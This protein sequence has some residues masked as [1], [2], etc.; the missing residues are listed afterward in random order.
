MII[1]FTIQ[2]SFNNINEHQDKNSIKQEIKKNIQTYIFSLPIQWFSKQEQDELRASDLKNIIEE[3]FQ[4]AYKDHIEKA[5]PIEI[6]AINHLPEVDLLSLYLDNCD[7][8]D[9]LQKEKEYFW[10]DYNVLIP[11]EIKQL[12]KYEKNIES[13]IT[14]DKNNT[15]I[16]KRL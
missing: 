10:E 11:S 16:A 8:Y 3:R 9:S 13:I 15:T 2:T 1:A 12:E 7:C 14:G 6:E 4:E 5:Y